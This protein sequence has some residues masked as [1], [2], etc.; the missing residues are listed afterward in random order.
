MAK[1]FLSC[2]IVFI[3]LISCTALKTSVGTTSDCDLIPSSLRTFQMDAFGIIYAI[4]R[5]NSLITYDPE[6]TKL[7]EYYNN[8]LGDISYLDISNPRK[9][10]VFFRDFQK[11]IFLDNTLSEIER[12]E[13][14]MDQ[15]FDIRAIG[16]SRDNNIWVY[17]ALDYKL[18][19]INSQGTVLMESNP[20]QSYLDIDIIPDYIIEADNEVYLMDELNG[21]AT[22]D[23]F[24]N[25]LTYTL[26]KAESI[27]ISNGI[28]S[29]L[30]GGTLYQKNNNNPLAEEQLIFQFHAGVR[31][32]AVHQKKIYYLDGGCLKVH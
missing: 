20:L 18:K 25:F 29:Y 16:S 11:I 31:T 24:G 17:D 14:T 15:A 2:G 4:D 9:L 13:W 23:N 26:I 27:N 6:M 5:R 12:F 21:I 1:Y 7:F 8:G 32:A 30:K 3:L 10:L 28:L 22:F 19:K